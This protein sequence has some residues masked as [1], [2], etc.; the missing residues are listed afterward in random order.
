MLCTFLPSMDLSLSSYFCAFLRMVLSYFDMSVQ[1]TNWRSPHKHFRLSLSLFIPLW[2]L[3][4]TGDALPPPLVPCETTRTKKTQFL[5]FSHL[6][7][8]F[9]TLSSLIGVI[10]SSGSLFG[11]MIVRNCIKK[12]NLFCFSV[13]RFFCNG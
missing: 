13:S 8:R 2:F 4:S 7:S 3:R 6:I 9:T 10:F 1:S 5:Y 11:Q 12:F